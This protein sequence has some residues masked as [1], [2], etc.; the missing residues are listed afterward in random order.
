MRS[1]IRRAT[2]VAG[3]AAVLLG[4][5][6][7]GASASGTPVLF[8]SPTTSAGT[9]NYGTLNA[10]QTASQTF[11]LTNSGSMA[12]SAL[13]ITL[14]GS[15]AFTKIGDTCSGARVKANR[16]CNV[17]VQYAPATSGQT[18]SAT[19][20][21]T[22]SKPAAAAS[23]TLKGA[24]AKASTAIATSPSPG[25][26]AGGTTVTDTATL[27]GGSSPRGTIEFKLYGPS[28]TANCSGTPV[29]DET[30]NVTGNGAYTTPAGANPSQAGSYWWTASYSGDANNNPAATSCGDESVTIG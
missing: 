24:S 15:S 28:A 27:S 3:A 19:L 11:T 22:S 29:D 23:L 1:L 2:V 14:A 6:V 4:P 20:T 18:D 16:S 8:W 7:G 26:P 9:Y 13:K 21:A 17:T 12:T 5:A 30:V 10:G 25:G